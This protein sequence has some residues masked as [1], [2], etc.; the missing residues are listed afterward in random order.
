MLPKITMEEV[1][2]NPAPSDSITRGLLSPP[3]HRGSW[4]YFLPLASGLERA[5]SNTCDV[6][7]GEGGMSSTEGPAAVVLLVKSCPT[8]LGAPLVGRPC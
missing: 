2:L 8:Q 7:L 6:L 1:D 3:C 5:A 4:S